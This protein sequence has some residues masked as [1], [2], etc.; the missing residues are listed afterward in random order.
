LNVGDEIVSVRVL[1]LG[2]GSSGNALLISN[3]VTSLLVDCGVGPRAIVAGLRSFGLTWSDLGAVVVSH[4]HIDHVRALATVR[5]QGVPI[6]CTDGTALGARI[7]AGIH[8]CITA[9]DCV[10]PTG[11]RLRP[12]ATSHDAEEP[13]GFEIGIGEKQICV[14]T[15]TGEARDHFIDPIRRADLVIVEANHDETMLWNGPYPIHLKR[16]VASARGHLSN[17]AAGEL[18]REALNGL[19]SFPDIWLGHLSESNNTPAKAV[20][21]VRAALGGKA[22]C[23]NVTAMS[24][25][26]NQR[27]SSDSVPPD[28][29]LTL[30]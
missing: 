21:T 19:S 14:I 1:N 10:L 24:R 12:F 13:C 16:R 9:G 2:S 22:T 27:W 3:G 4:E 6:I 11:L 7:G 8:R 23:V 15:D 30:F 25:H 17:G 28:R 26:G 5:R 29:Q 18:L 20:A